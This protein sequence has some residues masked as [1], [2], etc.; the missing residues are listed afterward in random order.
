[1]HA[2]INSMQTSIKEK[3]TKVVLIVHS[4]VQIKE[5]ISSF[6]AHYEVI[7]TATKIIAIINS[8]YSREL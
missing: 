1:M 4:K 3:K 8:S 2:Y 6:N 5:K 7:I